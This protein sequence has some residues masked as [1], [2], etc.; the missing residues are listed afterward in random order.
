MT[1]QSCG[2]G[3]GVGKEVQ[4]GRTYVYL[5]LIHIV[6]WQKPTQ[7]YKAIMLQLKIII[8]CKPFYRKK[9]YVPRASPTPPPPYFLIRWAS[10]VV[11]VVKK[12]PANA[13]NIWD[14]DSIPGSGRFLGRKR[15]PTPVLLSGESQG[16]WSLAG[17]S[18]WGHKESDMTE[19]L[20][21]F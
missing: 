11:L 9:N 5:R 10:Q 12:S 7:Y 13:G 19:H 1:T 3:W 4:E 2:M 20:S 6:V 14:T 21:A 8:I 18:P 16:Q 15:Q 17:Y